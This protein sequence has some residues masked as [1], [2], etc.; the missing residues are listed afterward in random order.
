MHNGHGNTPCHMCENTH[1]LVPYAK[2]LHMLFCKRQCW[3]DYNTL[4]EVKKQ[5]QQREYLQ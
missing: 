2:L 5:A 4:M 3:L 1:Y